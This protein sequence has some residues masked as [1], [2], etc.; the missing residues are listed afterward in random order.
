M[1]GLHI[2][3]DIYALSVR[4]CSNTFGKFHRSSFNRTGWRY[5][6]GYYLNAF[7]VKG[8]SDASPILYTRQ[9]LPG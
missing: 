9:I 1:T 8:L 3:Y 2:P 4:F 6:T 7:G 5:S